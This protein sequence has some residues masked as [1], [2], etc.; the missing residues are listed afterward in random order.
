MTFNHRNHMTRKAIRTSGIAVAALLWAAN[1][2]AED[3]LPKD[4]GKCGAG[5]E[6]FENRTVLQAADAWH[7]VAGCMRQL[8]DLWNR[9]GGDTLVD[10]PDRPALSTLVHDQIIAEMHH[11]WVRFRLEDGSLATFDD[12]FDADLTLRAP[13]QA[14][15]QV[16]DRGEPYNAMG[17][18]GLAYFLYQM[19][20]RSEADGLDADSSFYRTLARGAVATVTREVKD[21]GLAT[22]APCDG[23]G[24]DARC[25]WYHSVTRRDQPAGAGGTLNQMLHAVR[26][27]GMIQ[28][29][30]ARQEW[31]G[32]PDLEPAIHAGMAQLFQGKPYAGPGTIPTLADFKSG[33]TDDD[34]GEWAW[35]GFNTQQDTFGKGYFLR[36]ATRNCGYHI[37]VLQ[38]MNGALGR[39]GQQDDYRDVVSAARTSETLRS[40]RLAAEHTLSGSLQPDQVRCGEGTSDD[41]RKVLKSGQN[42]LP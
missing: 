13:F 36:D 24:T 11:P 15:M 32:E 6:T 7:G 25:A 4:L 21:G 39:A 19:A 8:R 28:D 27:M 18:T 17:Q 12:V 22:Y 34:G 23:A 29:F 16:N 2:S 40:F 35:Y 1:A 31:Q 20:A 37:H 42:I 14:V 38:L 3:I 30:V 26:D 5:T 9:K 33:A 41:I 10:L